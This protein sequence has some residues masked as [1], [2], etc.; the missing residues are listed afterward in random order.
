MDFLNNLSPKGIIVL[1][2]TS[3]LILIGHLM[4]IHIDSLDWVLRFFLL[5]ITVLSLIRGIAM[6]RRAKLDHEVKTMIFYRDFKLFNLP[7]NQLL[8]R[9]EEI[10]HNNSLSDEDRSFAADILNEKQKN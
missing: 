2:L 10:V 9:L 6:Q 8:T 3:L 7:E 1:G 5:V 4:F